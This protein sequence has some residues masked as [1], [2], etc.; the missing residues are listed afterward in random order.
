[1]TDEEIRFLREW[2]SREGVSFRDDKQLIAQA[3]RHLNLE[4]LRTNRYNRIAKREGN[5]ETSGDAGLS[6]EEPR[7]AL[8][9]RKASGGLVQR[10]TPSAM[11]AKR[12]ARGDNNAS[13][14]G[15]ARV[16]ADLT[17][18]NAVAAPV[19]STRKEA[20]PNDAR[21]EK[22]IDDSGTECD[23]SDMTTITIYVEGGRAPKQLV[24]DY[25]SDRLTGNTTPRMATGHTFIGVGDGPL[26]EQR[27]YGFY[28]ATSWFGETGIIN[29]N[30]GAYY[31]G[32]TTPLDENSGFTP[33]NEHKFTQAKSF[34]ACKSQA[35]KLE[36]AI[37]KDIERIKKNAS[38]APKYNLMKLQCTTWA[39]KHLSELK[40]SPPESFSPHGA[41]EEL[42]SERKPEN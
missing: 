23:C 20:A 41:L 36:A 16:S 2:A 14:A 38:D 22:C 27:A 15:P 12:T 4:D 30:V 1:M 25:V 31:P 8:P 10:T 42:Q 24:E 5:A 17:S 28:P 33:E 18:R 3:A 35:A 9:I 19:V 21:E 13:R 39:A 26:S 32:E 40:F 11:L 37:Q 29:T 34:K 6:S 7:Q